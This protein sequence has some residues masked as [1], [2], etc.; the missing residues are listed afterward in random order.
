MKKPDAKHIYIKYIRTT[1]NSGD[2]GRRP[3]TSRLGLGGFSI[4]PARRSPM[5]QVFSAAM[6]H[7]GALA[8]AE[9]PQGNKSGVFRRG[10]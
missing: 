5:D 6:A 2:G 10:L 8:E 1:S 3:L 4:H 9:G 7:G